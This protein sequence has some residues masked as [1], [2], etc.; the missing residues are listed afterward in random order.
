MTSNRHNPPA[1]KPTETSTHAEFIC[2]E[3][4]PVAG[5]ADAAMMA[6]GQPGL[7]RRF[8]W[9][10]VQYEIVGVIETWKT[11][12]PCRHGSGE[13]YLRRHWYK[14]QVNPRLVMTV[15][16]DRQAKNRRKPKSR[17]WVYTVTPL[18]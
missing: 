5:L 6:R 10:N 8:T 16:C 18:E 3:L 1:A 13:M 4:T 2:Q 15:Y 7:P 14:I 17:W 11:Q 9:R 12:G